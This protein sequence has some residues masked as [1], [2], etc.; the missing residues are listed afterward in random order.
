VATGEQEDDGKTAE[1]IVEDVVETMTAKGE[2]DTPTSDS[3]AP[4]PG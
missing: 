4:P 1:D 3:Q 2:H